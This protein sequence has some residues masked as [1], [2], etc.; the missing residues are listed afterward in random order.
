MTTIVGGDTSGYS[1]IGSRNMQT[2]PESTKNSEMTIANFGR[3]MKIAEN[4]VNPLF[5]YFAGSAFPTGFTV[6]PGTAL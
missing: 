6:P 3:L 5:A 2:S 1:A 4:M